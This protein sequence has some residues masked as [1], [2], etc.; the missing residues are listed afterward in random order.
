MEAEVK[1]FEKKIQDLMKQLS[2]SQSSR[3]WKG[4]LK[5]SAA[6][7]KNE[8]VAEYRQ[9]LH[10]GRYKTKTSG[11]TVSHVEVA[12]V[13]KKKYP[14]RNFELQFLVGVL[15]EGEDS[16]YQGFGRSFTSFW[17][18]KGTRNHSIRKSSSLRS[19]SYKAMKEVSGI[20]EHNLQSNI[21]QSHSDNFIKEYQS[22]FLKGLE[23][24]VKRN[25]KK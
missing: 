16:T 7:M 22:N 9:K 13:S 21:L 18:E 24:A 10:K 17:Y 1:E 25:A 12:D 2:E 15:D 19:R 4:S 23:R 8:M 20:P 5:K 14:L 11:R 6:V 3:I